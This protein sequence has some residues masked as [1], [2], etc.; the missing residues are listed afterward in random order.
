MRY[1]PTPL[2]KSQAYYLDKL[3]REAYRRNVIGSA[4]WHQ[5]YSHIRAPCSSMY[6]G[7][8]MS[9][10]F[11]KHAENAEARVRRPLK[12]RSSRSGNWRRIPA[13]LRHPSRMYIPSEENGVMCLQSSIEPLYA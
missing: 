4:A 12:C 7:G 8:L 1:R 9:R 5:K 10:C 2:T 3:T 13:T 11:L 6:G